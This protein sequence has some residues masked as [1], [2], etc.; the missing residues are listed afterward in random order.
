MKP[1]E[2]PHAEAPYIVGEGEWEPKSALP[3]MW[4][5]MHECEKAGLDIYNTE[6]IVHWH[7]FFQQHDIAS[8]GEFLQKLNEGRK[9]RDFYEFN[10]YCLAL[11]RKVH[12]M[13]L[14][15]EMH[16]VEREL[17]E[18]RMS[19]AVR[20]EQRGDEYH[21]DPGNDYWRRRASIVGPDYRELPRSYEKL[22]ASYVSFEEFMADH[23]EFDG[24]RDGE[25]EIQGQVSRDVINKRRKES[26]Q[27]ARTALG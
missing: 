14:A 6:T 10:K 27:N 13:Q 2:N 25:L 1:A 9:K 18:E 12:E 17:I 26:A 8:F 11:Y 22:R 21:S 20:R 3:E 23:K 24:P 16:P 7:I 4:E 19:G 5:V 15:G